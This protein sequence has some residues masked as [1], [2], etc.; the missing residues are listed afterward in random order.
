M[1]PKENAGWRRY[2]H[3]R[4]L[5]QPSCLNVPGKYHN[6]IRVRISNQQRA[7]I[8]CQGEM[9]RMASARAHMLQRHQHVTFNAENSDVVLPAIAHIKK[10]TVAT[11][12]NVCSRTWRIIANLKGRVS[13]QFQRSCSSERESGDCAVEFIDKVHDVITY[14]KMPRSSARSESHSL[15]LTRGNLT[16]PYGIAHQLVEAEI[17]H[18][19]MASVH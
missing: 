11:Q 17:G 16:A 9:T 3:P 13:A 19:Q 2:R 1:S 18:V 5:R 7:L 8:R 4:D 12:V 6:A 15:T 14:T 10:A